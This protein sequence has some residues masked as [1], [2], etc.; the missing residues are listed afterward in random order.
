MIMLPDKFKF[1]SCGSKFFAERKS[2]GYQVTSCNTGNAYKY[3]YDDSPYTSRM[4]EMESNISKGRWVIMET[5]GVDKDGNPKAFTVDDIKVGMRVKTANGEM[6][7]AMPNVQH[8]GT[9]ALVDMTGW[10]SCKLA[11]AGSAS[12]Y[13]VVEVYDVPNANYKLLNLDKHGD[14]LWKYVEQKQPTEFEKRLAYFQTHIDAV[15]EN[16]AS[17]EREYEELKKQGA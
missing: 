6:Y 3:T 8:D 14:L 17:L 15:K 2:Y 9:L 1:I 12:D 13:N 7:I 4:E 10:I 5:N 11:D 16:L